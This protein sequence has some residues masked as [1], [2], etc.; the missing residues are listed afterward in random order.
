MKFGTSIRLLA[1]EVLVKKSL[2]FINYKFNKV[3]ILESTSIEY[4]IGMRFGSD[5]FLAFLWCLYPIL[6]ALKWPLIA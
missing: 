2:L 6:A 1:R 4:N 5:K 3:G